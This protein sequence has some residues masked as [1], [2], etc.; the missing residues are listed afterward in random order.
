MKRMKM[1][2]DSED[3]RVKLHAKLDLDARTFELC[4]G[5]V[6]V[7]ARNEGLKGLNLRFD[8][9]GGYS[10]KPIFKEENLNK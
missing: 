1:T 10:V 4:M 6:A 9:Y 3:I 8:E 2:I 5:L 7:Y